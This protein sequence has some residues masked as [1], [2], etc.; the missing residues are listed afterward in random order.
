MRWLKVTGMILPWLLGLTLMAMA[1]DKN[2]GI[3]D[4]RHITF[5]DPVRIGNNL[6]KAGEYEV[7]H[8]MQ[9]EEHIMVFTSESDKEQV[10][11]KCTLVPLAKKADQSSTTYE[12]NAANERVV[13]ELV[14]RGDSA[15]HVF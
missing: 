3:S 12:L 10:K 6:L 4:L 13:R 14:F 1:A 5:R 11:V 15:K 9:G 2:L 7:R 8:T